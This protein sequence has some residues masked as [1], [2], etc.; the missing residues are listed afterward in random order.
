DAMRA[1]L[2]E[3]E[4]SATDEQ[5]AEASRALNAVVESDDDRT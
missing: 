2:A 1:R 3:L 5:L 4:E